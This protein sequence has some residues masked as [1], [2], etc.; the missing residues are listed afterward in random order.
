MTWE[1]IDEPFCDFIAMGCNG[2]FSGSYFHLVDSSGS[3]NGGSLVSSN[4]YIAGDIVTMNDGS[5]CW[6]YVD[7]AKQLSYSCEA[8][9]PVS[10]SSYPRRL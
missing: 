2:A 8:C 1:Q 10:I 4:T 9:R 7:V 6:P 5:I 3:K